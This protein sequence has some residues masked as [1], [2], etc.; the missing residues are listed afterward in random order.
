M[1]LLPFLRSVMNVLFSLAIIVPPLLVASENA[2]EYIIPKALFFFFTVDLILFITLIFPFPEKKK[3]FQILQEPIS[4]LLLLFLLIHWITGIT[5]LNLDRSLW[6]LPF[7]MLGI[8]ALTHSILFYFLLRIFCEGKK[9]YEQLALYS[10][11]TSMVVSFIAILQLFMPNFMSVHFGE[12]RPISTLGNE[13]FLSF[14]L[15]INFFLAWWLTKR[16]RVRLWR[17]LSLVGMVMM[18]TA[19][20]GTGIRGVFLGFLFGTIMIVIL[21]C[22]SYFKKNRSALTKIFKYGVLVMVFAF[23]WGT[24]LFSLYPE[25]I[26]TKNLKRLSF[27]S[28]S[29]P[30]I[31]TRWIANF[32]SLKAFLDH[33]FLGVGPENYEYA[34]NQHYDPQLFNYGLQETIFDKAHNYYFQILVETGIGGLILFLLLIMAI[35]WSVRSQIPLLGLF[36][37]IFLVLLFEVEFTIFFSTFFFV[38]A[39]ASTALKK[40]KIKNL[41]PVW[42]PRFFT[43]FIS[44][45]SM[46]FIIVSLLYYSIFMITFYRNDASFLDFTSGNIDVSALQEQFQKNLG[47]ARWFPYVKQTELLRVA[48][49]VNHAVQADPEILKNFPDSFFQTV[50]GLIEES[51]TLYPHELRLSLSKCFFYKTWAGRNPAVIKKAEECFRNGLLIYPSY[52]VF[53]VGLTDLMIAHRSLYTLEDLIT[54]TEELI[55]IEPQISKPYWIL[56]KLYLEKEDRPKAAEAYKKAA[57]LGPVINSVKEILMAINPLM[58][59]KHYDTVLTFYQKAV[60][61]EPSNGLLRTKLASIY[62]ELK[63][64]KNA[65]KEAEKAIESDPSLQAGSKDFFQALDTL[66][67]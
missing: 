57:E 51:L 42:A 36:S 17:F 29:S 35:L 56:A 9:T 59:S 15:L 41:H 7:R 50:N 21:E 63:D 11:F 20:F 52:Q 24:L 61:L 4:I 27:F 10:M 55:A 60:A 22:I 62:L 28:F 49:D 33:P 43:P 12:Y 67:R 3:L 44:I 66:I 37:S 16:S 65:R 34:F 39:L 23:F 54:V 14:Y 45:A 31:H 2:F 32:I 47:L 25:A 58:E 46:A 18:A 8:I 6:G 1:S 30:S 38:L 48:S 13:S 19:F 64:E 53:F 26:L 5:G 40:Q